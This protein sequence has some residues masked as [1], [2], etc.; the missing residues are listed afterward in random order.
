M[1]GMVRIPSG[2]ED[3]LLSAVAYVGPV[4]VAIDANSNAFRVSNFHP[5]SNRISEHRN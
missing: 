1:S 4:T 5:C 2:S 3:T